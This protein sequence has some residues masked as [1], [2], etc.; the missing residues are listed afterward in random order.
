M[1]SQ[2]NTTGSGDP[3]TTENPI[4][5]KISFRLMDIQ[6]MACSA[7]LLNEAIF[8]AASGIGDRD[9]MGAIQSV[10][11]EINNKLLIVREW[12]GEIR[13]ELA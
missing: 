5:K 3:T 2:T 13:E 9:H 6:D 10:S 12:I 1:N 7:R 4:V 8:M 11:E